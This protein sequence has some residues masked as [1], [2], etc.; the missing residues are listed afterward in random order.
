MSKKC[1]AVTVAARLVGG[2]ELRCNLPRGHFG[3]C[4]HHFRGGLAT[5]ALRSEVRC[6]KAALRIAD[7]LLSHAAAVKWA[8][9]G[10]HAAAGAWENTAAGYLSART[11]SARQPR[12]NTKVL[13]PGHGFNSE[14]SQRA[15]NG[16]RP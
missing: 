2:A 15:E 6:L 9:T 10:D 16:G 7:D 4:C 8:M 11:L 1:G 14:R 5:R 13:A 12:R 3:G